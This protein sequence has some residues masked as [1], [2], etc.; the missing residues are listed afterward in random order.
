MSGSITIIA[1]DTQQGVPGIQV[2]YVLKNESNSQL[3]NPLTVI[4]DPTG[5][6]AFEF[7]SDPPYGDFDRW[8]YV[9]VDAIINDPIISDNSRTEFEQYN[10]SGQFNPKYK[11]DAEDGK[12]PTWAYVLLALVAILIGVGTVSY[13]HLTLPTILLV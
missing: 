7:N 10:S 11:F 5:Q 12:V 2:T 13:T 1:N 8:G 9:Y 3:T 6:A 4:T